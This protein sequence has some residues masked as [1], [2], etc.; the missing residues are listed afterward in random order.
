M[1]RFVMLN[2][3]YT[4]LEVSYFQDEV[5]MNSCRDQNLCDFIICYRTKKNQILV[6]AIRKAM[7]EKS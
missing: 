3:W 7:L 1:Q 6:V 5:H 2:R 4:V